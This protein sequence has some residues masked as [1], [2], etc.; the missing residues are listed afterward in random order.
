MIQEVV[1]AERRAP[2]D[3]ARRRMSAGGDGGGERDR[4]PAHDEAVGQAEQGVE[5]ERDDG[6][7][8]GAGSV[9]GVT[10]RL[11][12]ITVVRCVAASSAGD[13]IRH[14]RW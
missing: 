12:D 5:V 4:L 14:I 8:H 9:P 6:D 13:T 3:Q 7:R 2:G 1:G 10:C 11:A